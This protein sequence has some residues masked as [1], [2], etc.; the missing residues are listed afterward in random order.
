MT[1]SKTWSCGLDLKID[2]IL[3]L[4]L[5]SWGSD[6]RSTIEIRSCI[7][8]AISPRFIYITDLTRYLVIFQ[9]NLPIFAAQI[10]IL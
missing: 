10:V 7:D 1:R 4:V 2:K 9:Q 8:I 5:W 6:P 3:N